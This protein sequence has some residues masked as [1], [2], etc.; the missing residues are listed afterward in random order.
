MSVKKVGISIAVAGT[1]VVGAWLGASIYVGRTTAKWVSTVVEQATKQKNMRLVNLQ[2]HQGLFSSTGS[3]EIRINELGSDLATGKQKLSVLVDYRIAN[4]LLPQSSMRF[5]WNMK[6]A[7]EYAAEFNRM[8]GSELTLQGQG[9]LAYGGRAVSSLKLPELVMRNG[10]DRL[11]ISPSTGQMAWLGNAF[12]F[13][14]K[15]DRI[16]L[17]ADGDPVDVTGVRASADITNRNRG[18]GS[19]QFAIDKFSTKTGTAEGFVLKSTIAQREDRIDITLNHTLAS[20][21][22]AGQKIRDLLIDL[23]ISDLD[24]GSIDALSAIG[25]DSDNFQSLT[26]DEQSRAALAGRRLLNQGFT[27]ALPKISAQVGAGSV[28]GDFKLAFLKSEDAATTR[29]SAAKSIQASGQLA[30]TGKVIDSTQKMMAVMLG[31]VTDSKE[32]LKSNFTFSGNTL[33]ANGKSHDVTDSL[34]VIDA[35]I[36]GIIYPQ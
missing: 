21:D 7:G 26:A 14:W 5:D 12:S 34:S 25:N 33:K 20:L 17:R 2:H 13:D 8:F 32:G 24:M 28:K 23:V 31:L 15:T 36:N 4:L 1:L 3:F 16:S 22:I 10:D 27:I 11:Q 30:A 35:Y 6:P 29:F 18:I 9:K 19:M